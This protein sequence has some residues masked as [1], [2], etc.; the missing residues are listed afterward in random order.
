MSS[1][2]KIKYVYSN[3]CYQLF[4]KITHIYSLNKPAP[5]FDSKMLSSIVYFRYLNTILGNLKI[6]GTDKGI[7]SIFFV[8]KVQKKGPYNDILKDCFC[9][10][11]AYFN[12]ELEQF[13]LKLDLKGTDFQVKVWKELIKIPFGTTLS[14]KDLANKTGNINNTRAVANAN[15]KNPIAIVIPCHR[16]IGSDGSLTGYAWGIEKK[17]KLL[18]LERALPQL[19]LF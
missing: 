1:K 17:R 19:S 8:E 9:Q 4:F 12:G 14:Y 5:Y 13:D 3:N 10:L 16:V 7:S 11:N 6:S 18:E 2:D 15:A